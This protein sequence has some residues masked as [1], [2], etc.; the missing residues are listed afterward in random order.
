MW[1]CWKKTVADEVVGK[2]MSVVVTAWGCGNEEVVVGA[3]GGAGKAVH[4]WYDG[5]AGVYLTG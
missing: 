3:E 5:V 2:W 1:W 4:C